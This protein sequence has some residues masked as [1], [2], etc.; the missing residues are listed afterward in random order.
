[1]S[2]VTSKLYTPPATEEVQQPKACG[3]TDVKIKQAWLGGLAALTALGGA[4]TVAAGVTAATFTPLIFA[5]LPL[6]LVSG[7]CVQH[8]RSL[9]D[10]EDPKVLTE[11]RAEALKQ[12]LPQIVEK[13]G[14]EKIFRYAILN[15]CQFEAFYRSHADGLPFG[16]ILTFFHR[17][18]RGLEAAISQTPF[19][20]GR[21]EPFTIP[22]PKEWQ[23]KFHAETSHIR[24]DK[25]LEQ[26]PLS[27]LKAFQIVS[28]KQ[29]KVLDDV[30]A[31]TEAFSSKRED[32]NRQFRHET[33]YEHAALQNAKDLAQLTYRS[34]PVH[35][36]LSQIELDESCN[37]SALRS[38]IRAR[39]CE[40]ENAFKR[41]EN[42]FYSYGCHCPSFVAQQ[43]INFRRRQM[44]DVIRNLE[45][46]EYDGINRIHQEAAIRKIPVI[47]SK[48]IA[49][50]LRNRALFIA[51]E[52][53]RRATQFVRC[54][55]DALHAKNVAEYETKIVSLEKRY[56][57]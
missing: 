8:A 1:M 38:N 29:M 46:R 9:I 57:A 52:E 43:E 33:P 48:Q 27:D 17:A 14:W 25:I 35:A 10:Y 15:P 34:H 13:H 41:F 39:I 6:F 28:P 23:T 4:G 32:L 45:S 18:T 16:S 11:L 44:R 40:E 20:A 5:A 54:K 21:K 53:F 42:S 37:I 7:L 36:I 2:A 31:T 22:S 12:S 3:W 19:S 24:C 26:Y 30:V 55:I 51:N 47:H 50:E 56:R 49:K